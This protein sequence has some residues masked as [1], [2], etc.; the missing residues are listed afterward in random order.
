MR[1]S[2]TVMSRALMSSRAVTAVFWSL[3]KSHPGVID[4]VGCGQY[5]PKRRAGSKPRTAAIPSA[6][7][8]ALARIAD[9]RRSR[10]AVIGCTMIDPAGS[11]R[12]RRC[13]VAETTRPIRRRAAA[14]ARVSNATPGRATTT[15]M[16]E[17]EELTPAVPGRKSEE[18]VGADD[19]RERARAD[20]SARSSSSVSHGDSC[21][22]RRESRAR[23][24]RAPD[25]RR[26]RARPSRAGGIAVA[27]GAA[28][29]GGSPAGMKRTAAR[30]SAGAHLAREPRDARSE[31]D[32]TCRRRCREPSSCSRDCSAACSGCAQRQA[33]RGRSSARS[34][35]PV[36]CRNAISS[37]STRGRGSRC[38]AG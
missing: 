32:R 3:V 21:A 28:R 5:R 9:A 6:R 4:R 36:R 37:V 1:T 33:N 24:L 23:R 20:L 17:L 7:A 16:R 19:E 12:E 14:A 10:C 8:R 38:G 13:V 18:R 27:T 22:A 2:R 30:S 15:T 26:S 35:I 34:A 25:D 29:C 31:R 11:A